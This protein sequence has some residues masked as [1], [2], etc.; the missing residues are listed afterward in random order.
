[1]VQAE[2][3]ERARARILGFRMP[4]PGEFSIGHLAFP[5]H[6]VSFG[7]IETP[8]APAGSIE[9]EISAIFPLGPEE[10]TLLLLVDSGAVR[11]CA[12]RAPDD[13]LYTFEGQVTEYSRKQFDAWP[14]DEYSRTAISIA[15]TP[16]GFVTREE[17]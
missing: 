12:F 14:G 3:V 13:T 7:G 6:E 10:K 11:K 16:I 4:K 15:L 8:A 2:V 9:V 1:M 17:S 5:V